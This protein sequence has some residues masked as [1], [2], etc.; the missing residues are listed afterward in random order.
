MSMQSIRKYFSRKHMDDS[1]NRSEGPW[2]GYF[3]PARNGIG[4]WTDRK[5][6]DASSSASF[7]L[8]GW[9]AA[10]QTPLKVGLPASMALRTVWL[11]GSQDG[12]PVY[13]F[14]W[15]AA[16]MPVQFTCLI[17]S[18][19][20]F[21]FQYMCTQG[22][23]NGLSNI[24]ALIAP[25]NGLLSSICALQVLRMDCFPMFFNCWLIWP[26]FPYKLIFSAQFN[27][28]MTNNN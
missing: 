17:E 26:E 12:C 19:E 5:I 7:D 11:S 20:W 8:P 16:R 9:A 4:L 3:I 2:T 1:F 21:V 14:D 6:V 13:L 27:W 24:C 10:P 15:V 25:Q 22:P 23:Q 18:L 28:T